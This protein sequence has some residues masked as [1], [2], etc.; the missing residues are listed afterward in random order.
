MRNTMYSSGAYE[1]N[2]LRQLQTRQT[3]R[4]IHTEKEELGKGQQYVLQ[5]I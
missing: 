3:R 4:V 2:N 1:Q 5:H